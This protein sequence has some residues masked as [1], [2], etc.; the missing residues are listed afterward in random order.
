ML[1]SISAF[2]QNKE[3]STV[4][5]NTIKVEGIFVGDLLLFYKDDKGKLIINPIILCDCRKC[6]KKRK[7]T[8]I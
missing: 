4:F 7:K 2:G 1:F 8:K 6:I 5:D 3:Y